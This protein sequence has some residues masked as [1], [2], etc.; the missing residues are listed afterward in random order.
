[1]KPLPLPRTSSLVG[2][3]NTGTVPVDDRESGLECN[4]ISWFFGNKCK[5]ILVSAEK[6]LLVIQ[7]RKA[8]QQ[9]SRPLGPRE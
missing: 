4:V 8:T 7:G 6:R 9:K 1:M 5:Q 2:R 3:K